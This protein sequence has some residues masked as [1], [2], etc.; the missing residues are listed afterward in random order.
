MMD[1]PGA[2]GPR[3]VQV[4]VPL[5]D[6]VVPDRIPPSLMDPGSTTTPPGTSSATS[7]S[8]ASD[9]SAPEPLVTVTT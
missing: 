2:S 6:A 1:S 3:P 5:P 9:T 8:N 4:M 7:M